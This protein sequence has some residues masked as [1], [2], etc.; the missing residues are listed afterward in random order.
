MT[1]QEMM[2]KMVKDFG[3]ENA[4]VID[5]FSWCENNPNARSLDVMDAYNEYTYRAVREI[6]DNS[7]RIG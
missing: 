4:H 2:D 6:L 7:V 1:K 5:F 3:M